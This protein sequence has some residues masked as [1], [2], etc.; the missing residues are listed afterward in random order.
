MGHPPSP[1]QALFKGNGNQAILSILTVLIFALNKG[2]KL[3]L[4]VR[5]KE[6]KYYESFYNILPTT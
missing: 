5:I 6:Y 3:K 1:T 4:K 2:L